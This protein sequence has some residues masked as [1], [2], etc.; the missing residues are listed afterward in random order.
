LYRFLLRSSSAFSRVSG[1]CKA[2]TSAS[3]VVLRFP[4]VPRTPYQRAETNL[5]VGRGEEKE[6]EPQGL[7]AP[8]SPL[9]SK[10]PNTIFSKGV[11][12][13]RTVLLDDERFG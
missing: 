6:G 2:A 8:P 12:F 13:A 3:I 4:K 1:S 11:Q 10:S 5:P 9:K 7:L